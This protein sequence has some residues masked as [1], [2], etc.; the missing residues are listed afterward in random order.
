MSKPAKRHALSTRIWHWI[1]AISLIILFM[2]GLTI[3]NAHRYLYWGDWGFSPDQ[4]WLAVPRFPGWATIPSH[5]SLATARDWHTL[6]AL[7]FAFTLLV[8]MI[9]AL[10]N[11]HIKRDLFARAKEWKPSNIGRDIVEHLKF[12]FEHGEGKYNILQKIA[13]AGVVFVLLPLMIFTGIV[14]SP[15]HEAAWPWLTEIFGGRQSARSLHFLAAFGL[16]GFFVL[17]IALVLL[18]GPIGQIRD[19]ITGGTIEEERDHAAS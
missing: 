13:Y 14:M 9:A 19:M 1:N 2:S 7:V 4:A 11:G 16:F 18:A 15:G 10:R 6:F 17:H 3:S 12:N 5:Y 8:F